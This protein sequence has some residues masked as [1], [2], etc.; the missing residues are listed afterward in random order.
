ML[1]QRGAACE[2]AC[3]SAAVCVVLCRRRRSLF[4][5]PTC[6]TLAAAAAP[7]PPLTASLHACGQRPD[8]LSV[9]GVSRVMA[10]L[11]AFE[12][13]VRSSTHQQKG[14]LPTYPSVQGPPG[15]GSGRHGRHEGSRPGASPLAQQQASPLLSQSRAAARGV[16]RL[17]AGFLTNPPS[18]PPPPG[19]RL[20][21][22][23]L[24]EA[25]RVEVGHP[26]ARLGPLRGERPGRV[27]P[28]GAPPDTKL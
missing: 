8:V 5:P 2:L 20:R 1:L 4:A 24:G 16:R 19:R 28:A 27:P 12:V 14:V 11:L 7:P 17:R 22:R 15:Q 13:H 10:T 6:S 3:M 9:D 25:R 26:Q 23:R 18:N 21:R